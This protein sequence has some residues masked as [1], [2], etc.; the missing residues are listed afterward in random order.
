MSKTTKQIATRPVMPKMPELTEEQKKEQIARAY[1]QK[2][3][4]LAE[5]ILYNMVQ[6]AGREMVY[7]YESETGRNRHLEMV[8]MANEMSEEFIKVVYGHN[9]E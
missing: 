8:K 4:S 9:A 1:M 5:G 6:G 7:D 3:A 2:K